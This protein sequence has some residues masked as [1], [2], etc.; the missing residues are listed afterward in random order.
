MEYFAAKVP[1]KVQKP[2][3][4]VHRGNFHVTVFKGR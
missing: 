4:R 2:G 1:R 3:A